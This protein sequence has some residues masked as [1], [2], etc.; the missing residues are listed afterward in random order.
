MRIEQKP[1]YFDK[2]V[3]WKLGFQTS[4]KKKDVSINK[5]TIA[6]S[7]DRVAV[8]VAKVRE[9]RTL[10]NRVRDAEHGKQTCPQPKK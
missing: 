6:R 9:K 2:G 3:F 1:S 5:S 7:E 4:G 10:K 8:A